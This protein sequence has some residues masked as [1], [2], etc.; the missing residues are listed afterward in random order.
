MKT[1][2]P[3]QPATTRLCLTFLMLGA[4]AMTACQR[5]PAAEDAPAAPA[6]PSAKTTTFETGRLGAAIDNYAS[7]PTE[8]NRASVNLALAELD[9]EIAELEDAKLTLIGDRRAEVA[10]KAENLQSYRGDESAR[11]AKVQAGAVFDATPAPDS[12]SGAQKLE[13]TAVKV[14]DKVQEGAQK[15]GQSLE[16]AAHKTGEAIDDATR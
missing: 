8:Q 13:D 2:R 6:T 12:R 3:S 4:L 7:S 10:A 1:T 9:S 15:V 16:D 5:K 11:F 14:G